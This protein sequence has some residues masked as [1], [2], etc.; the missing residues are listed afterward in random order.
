MESFGGWD[1]AYRY[2]VPGWWV[3]PV[4]ATVIVWIAT[5]AW[6]RRALGADRA[7]AHRLFRRIEDGPWPRRYLIRLALALPFLAVSAGA[8]ALWY[9]A[10]CGLWAAFH[11]GQFTTDPNWVSLTAAGYGLV[12]IVLVA[13]A[14]GYRDRV[15]GAALWYGALVGIPLALLTLVNLLLVLLELVTDLF[16]DRPAWG[17]VGAALSV[18]AVSL[19]PSVSFA[20]LGWLTRV[21]W[22]LLAGRVAGEQA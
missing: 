5:L 13:I 20:L 22:S 21:G 16:L 9:L 2:V 8:V 18:V 4:Y 1:L 3:V 15:L 11:G 19:V 12:G 6:W 17:T 14:Y 7:W 10:G